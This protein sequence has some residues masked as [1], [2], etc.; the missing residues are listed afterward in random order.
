MKDFDF[1]SHSILPLSWHLYFISKLNC[2]FVVLILLFISFFT[3]DNE[4][5]ELPWLAAWQNQLFTHL[6]SV[7]CNNVNMRY[8]VNILYGVWHFF[9]SLP[10]LS[11]SPDR[12]SDTGFVSSLAH[13]DKT[14]KIFQFL[15]YVQYIFDLTQN[16][17]FT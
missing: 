9:I 1:I 8:Y 3:P 16:I 13:L 12:Q 2:N 14:R 4:D 11:Y 6:L 17:P 5:P 10:L 7:I 15:F